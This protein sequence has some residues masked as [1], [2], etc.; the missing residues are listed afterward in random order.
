VLLLLISEVSCGFRPSLT[1]LLADPRVKEEIDAAEKFFKRSSQVKRNVEDI[2]VECALCGIV[3]NEVEGFMAENITEQEIMNEIDQEICQALSGPLYA[4]CEAIKEE[5]PTIIANI[6]DAN[7]VTVECV[8]MGYCSAPINPHPDLLPAPIYTISL[9]LPP[10][11]RWQKICSNSTYQQVAQYLI[12]TISNLLPYGGKNMAMIGEMLNDYYYPTE[13]A[14]E[15]K[16]CAS[17][18]GI[19]Y[20]WLALFNLGY[21]ATDD[22]TSIVAQTNSGKIY[23]AR[24]MDFGVGMGFTESLREMLIQVDWQRGGKTVYHTTGFAG[25]AGALSAMKPNGF[26][27]TIDTRFYPEGMYQVFYEIIAAI[28]DKNASLVSFLSRAVVN[29]ENDFNSAVQNLGYDQLIADVYYIVAG[30]SAGQGAVI[31]RNRN[32]ASDIW[33]LNAPS[34]WFEVETNYDHWEPAPWYDDRV[35]P[36]NNA[37]VAM[38][39]NSLS[40]KGMLKV[41]TVKPVLNLQ[42][43]YTILAC[44]ADG[45]YQSYTRYCQYPCAE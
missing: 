41:L 11:Q 38:G 43:V 24:N 37:M 28:T 4:T 21:E 23:H 27:I 15:I 29:N 20:G 12:N 35:D 8:N 19:D 5:I 6:D 22:C 40:L 16:G 13:Y 10:I 44:P 3:L 33:M 14:Q 18:L 30:V 31:S 2:T 25:Y 39:R 42:T 34:R 1:Q 7:S 9:D 26:S 32:N 17:A 45:T 36:A